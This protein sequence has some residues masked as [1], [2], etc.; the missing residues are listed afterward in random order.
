MLLLICY[1][2]WHLYA[3]DERSISFGVRD[4][5]SQ[6]PSVLL[7]SD[8]TSWANYGILVYTINQQTRPNE[9]RW[10][11]CTLS[12]SQWYT[13]E[14]EKVTCKHPSSVILIKY[15]FEFNHANLLA[16]LIE[17]LICKL[18]CKIIEQI[19]GHLRRHLLNLRH[20]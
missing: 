12:A 9:S 13:K 10:S 2:T 3:N 18:P 4:S 5:E 7:L 11:R 16:H 14:C 6:L 8:R 19:R 17:N 15:C 1:S 20:N